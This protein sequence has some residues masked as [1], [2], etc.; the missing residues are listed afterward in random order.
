MLWVPPGPSQ[1][2]HTERGPWPQHQAQ[3][4][5]QVTARL[6]RSALAGRVLSLSPGPSLAPTVVL[7][8]VPTPVILS[9]VVDKARR[10]WREQIAAT[11]QVQ[12]SSRPLTLSAGVPGLSS[13]GHV[14]P[15]ARLWLLRPCPRLLSLTKMWVQSCQTFP[16]SKGS[17]KSFIF[18]QNIHEFCACGLALQAKQNTRGWNAGCWSNSSGWDG[19]PRESDRSVRGWWRLAESPCPLTC[20]TPPCAGQVAAAQACLVFLD[21]SGSFQHHRLCVS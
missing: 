6:P 21:V 13:A 7:H 1:P 15:C 16:F 19:I 10:S 12:D 5:P 18:M 3:N 11:G 20:R 8:P 4:S 14:S 17:Q 2:I 9:E